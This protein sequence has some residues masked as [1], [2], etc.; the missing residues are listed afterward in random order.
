MN[1]GKCSILIIPR[2]SPSALL[3]PG[4]PLHAWGHYGM[5]ILP[6]TCDPPGLASTLCQT[7]SFSSLSMHRCPDF[8][9]YCITPL[10]CCIMVL[11][12]HRLS[13][14]ILP[15]LT[16]F[17]G[18]RH[19]CSCSLRPSQPRPAYPSV[20]FISLNLPCPWYPPSFPDPP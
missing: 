12:V 9:I 1:A 6:S 17:C 8:C 19:P 14:L 7:P 2:L 13:Q 15:C 4:L 16:M 5:Q 18:I 11:S 10:H 3:T 20:P